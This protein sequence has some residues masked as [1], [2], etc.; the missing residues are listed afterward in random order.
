MQPHEIYLQEFRQ[1]A[2]R[3][4][5]Q[6]FDRD[7]AYAE[8]AHEAYR[9]TSD[10]LTEREA[11]D[12]ERALVLARGFNRAVQEWIRLERHDWDD[13]RERLRRI[14]NER[15]HARDTP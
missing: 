8:A 2:E 15:V 11:F 10:R 6:P 12:G 9:V 14:E 1:R 13:L 4:D 3:I 7:A 5:A